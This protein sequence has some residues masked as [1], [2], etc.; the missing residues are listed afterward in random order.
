MKLKEQ[1]VWCGE[2]QGDSDNLFW[3]NIIYYDFSSFSCIN[4]I[5]VLK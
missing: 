5:K 4:N 2:I 3:S 1:F